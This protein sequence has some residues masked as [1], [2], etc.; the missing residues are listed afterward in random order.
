MAGIYLRL[1]GRIRRDPAA[2]LRGRISVPAWEKAL[3]AARSLS[4]AGV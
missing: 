3:V 2:V 1:L 4:G